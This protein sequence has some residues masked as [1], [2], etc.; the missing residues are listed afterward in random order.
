MNREWSK[1]VIKMIFSQTNLTLYIVRIHTIKLVA[2][3]CRRPRWDAPPSSLVERVLFSKWESLAIVVITDHRVNMELDLQS[4]FGL[5][6]S[7][8]ETQ[9]QP[10][11]L[12]PPIPQR[13]GSNTRALLVSQ[14]R[15]HLF[16][17]PWSRWSKIVIWCDFVYIKGEFYVIFEKK[18]K[19]YQLQGIRRIKK[20][21]KTK[22][23][24]KK[25][26]H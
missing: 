6:Y 13:L 15:R 23:K 20:R 26:R 4:L 24:V 9:L 12:P 16:V 17:T 25:M 14:E 11:P 10:P 5:L 7:F 22:N 19:K 1:E 18:T 2:T 3:K 21:F 8:A